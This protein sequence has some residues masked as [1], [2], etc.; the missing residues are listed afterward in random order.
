MTRLRASCFLGMLAIGAPGCSGS[1]EVLELIKKEPPPPVSGV[2]DQSPAIIGGTLIVTRDDSTAVAA[3]PDRSAVWLVDLPTQGLRKRVSLPKDSEPGRVIE[4][5]A[6]KVHVA[7]RRTGQVIK[8]DPQSG[9]IEST[10]TICPA[11]RGMAYDPENDSLYVAC[12]GGELVTLKARGGDEASTWYLDDDLRDVVIRGS[13]TDRHLAV[14]RFRSAQVITVK[15]DGTVLGRVVPRQLRIGTNNTHSASTAWRMLQLPG[16]RGLMLHQR[17]I[18]ATTVPPF[19]PTPSYYGSTQTCSG[20]V[21]SSGVSMFPNAAGVG[22]GAVLGGITL[23]V[24]V[25]VTRD[26]TKLAVVSPTSLSDGSVVQVTE[27]EVG[28]MVPGGDPCVPPT[29]LPILQPA[30]PTA[31]AYDGK[32]KL[33][34]QSRSPSRL[35]S[36]TGWSIVLDGA[37][38]QL[39]EGHRLF[40]MATASRIA[41]A[42]CHPEGGDDGRVWAFAG[43]GLRRTQSLRGG[44]LAT[45]PF[46]WNGDLADLNLLM[47]EVF[48][49]RMGGPEVLPWQVQALGDWL[50]AQPAL[51]R[52]VPKD[53]Q[54]VERGRALYN[55]ATV[56]CASCH[57]GPHLTNNGQHDVGTGQTFQ[58]PSLIGIASRAPFMHNGCAATLRD[59]FDPT[60]GGSAHGK[61]S[62]LSPAQLDDLIAYLQTL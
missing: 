23:A 8:I 61:T 37:K 38:E 49:K 27:M 24:D 56:A 15:L 2:G 60:C 51:P 9:E 6:G 58:V 44:L 62:H 18:D 22:P 11:P 34:V 46:H 52:S 21:V 43:V 7:L 10:R 26:G 40:H 53:P 25:A 48:T 14:S 19:T 55:D 13:G 16:D 1:G 35:L 33:W 50:D 28:R 32:G 17:S 41:C 4:D 31:A 54:A 29:P 57:G 45:A 59:R 20:S 3:D 42:S 39:D 36:S 30:Q 12:A 47:G 5:A